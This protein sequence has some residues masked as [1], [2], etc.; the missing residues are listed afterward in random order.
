MA[1]IY[2]GVVKYSY[3]D[4]NQEMWKNSKN[5]HGELMINIFQ[6]EIFDLGLKG[7]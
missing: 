2:F 5:C 4:G 6:K 7:R 3:R 1:E